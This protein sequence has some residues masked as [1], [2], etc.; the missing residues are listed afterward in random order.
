MCQVCA[1]HDGDGKECMPVDGL[2]L[3]LLCYIHVP[4]VDDLSCAGREPVKNPRA[5]FCFTCTFECGAAIT[6]I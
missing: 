4:E 2:C 5:R 1:V 6:C 3:E